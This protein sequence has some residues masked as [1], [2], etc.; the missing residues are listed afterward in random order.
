MDETSAGLFYTELGEQARLNGVTVSIIAIEGAEA[1][2]EALSTVA[3][4]ARGQVDKVRKK[5]FGSVSLLNI[6]C[7]GG[8]SETQICSLC[9]SGP[10]SG[11]DRSDEFGLPSSRFALQRRVRRRVGEK[12]LARQGFGN[13][14]RKG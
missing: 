7:Q 11:G 9:K 12:K 4:Q 2:L 8:A 13:C 6:S 14:A 5:P 3:E 10:S 1:R